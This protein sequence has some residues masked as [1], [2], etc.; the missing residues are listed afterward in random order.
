MA[1]DS[2]G[3]FA[4][5][6]EIRIDDRTAAP[7]RRITRGFDAIAG[8]AKKAGRAF[9][10]GTLD[11]VSRSATALLEKPIRKFAAFEEQMDSVTAA[12]FD[13]TKAMD[14]AQ[15]KEMDA[16]V[17]ELSAKA[18]QLGADT[19][20]SATEAAAGMDI[21]AKNFAGSD[22]QKAQDIMK[23]MPG[24]LDTAAATKQTIAEAADVQTSAMN[25]FGLAAGDMGT[26]GDVLVK[27]AN[28]SATGLLD[29]GEALKYSGVTAKNANVDLETTLAMLGALGNAGKK[30][31][32]AGTGL[33]SVLGNLQ[34]NM[35]KQR[36]ALAALGINV[37]DKKGNLRPIVE[38]LTEIDK[39]ADKKFG[40]KGKGGVKRDRWLQGL[41]GMGSDK[42]TLAILTKQAGSGE[43]QKLVDANK[44]AAGTA[45][46]VAEAMSDNTVGAAKELDS[47][48]EELQLTIGEQLTP[49]LAELMG[50]AKGV[51]IE[52]AA[53][54][55]QNP[56]LARGISVL[57]GALGAAA[58][59]TRVLN[60]IMMTNP[61]VAAV[62][63]I[64]TAAYLIYE[65]WDPI[66]AFFAGII[67]DVSEALGP[68]VWLFSPLIGAAKLIM[69]NWTPIK[70]FFVDLWNGVT[71]AFKTA[72]DWI[73]DKIGWVGTKIEEF[74]V[75]I[76]T[77]AEFAAYE[78]TQAAKAEEGARAANND[79]YGA[80]FADDLNAGSIT[81]K[82][83]LG[84]AGA[85]WQKSFAA[86]NTQYALDKLAPAANAAPAPSD[87]DA[88]LAGMDDYYKRAPA[89]LKGDSAT[90]TI[91]KGDLKITIDSQGNVLKTEMNTAGD[92]GFETRVNRGG[93][94][95]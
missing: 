19:K 25:Q 44:A 80:L 41:V 1:R 4:A 74:K 93:Q 31:S 56:G 29:L 9:D 43:L 16:A 26:I 48:L 66:S 83:G 65:Y 85:G 50:G 53:W 17:A 72:I 35:K 10:N 49:K 90:G 22:L 36:S 55:K 68:A 81:G 92:P 77:P 2:N 12:T 95:A 20:Y 30:G 58:V 45:H 11:Q 63:A 94:A 6:I 14:P 27:T 57:V 91:F 15:V 32:V 75:S 76:M 21:L 13:L 84:D 18:R 70:G 28:T 33:A 3:R 54:T 37:S 24:I 89:M 62:T 61:I 59:A 39:A 78:V 34:S 69:D 42:E 87:F 47:A 8:S 52:V 23:A 38:L 82:G 51:V 5:G 46:L 73:M 60:V 71:G 67:N 64:A 7:L 79:T 86:D 40:G 88:M